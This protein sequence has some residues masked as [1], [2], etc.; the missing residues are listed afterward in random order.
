MPERALWNCLR[1]GRL[2]GLKFRRQHP[3]GPFVA[4]FYCHEADLVIELDGESHN[5]RA[6][7]DAHRTEYLE[8]QGFRVL[9]IGND[10]LLSDLEAVLRGIL[11][12]CEGAR[13]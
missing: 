2:S 9:R 8:K 10:D 5:G 7:A 4:D 6:A 3:V 1:S 12:A 13:R 11:I